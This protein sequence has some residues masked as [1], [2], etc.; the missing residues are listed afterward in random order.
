MEV[1]SDESAD[2]ATTRTAPGG[3]SAARS[4]QRVDIWHRDDDRA[5]PVSHAYALRDVLLNADARIFVAEILTA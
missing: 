3:S 2:V 5:V 4:A 1:G